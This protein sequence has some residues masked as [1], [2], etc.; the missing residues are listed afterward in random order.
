[1]TLFPLLSLILDYFQYCQGMQE[2]CTM[3]L[4]LCHFTGFSEV[5]YNMSGSFGFFFSHL[6]VLPVEVVTTIVFVTN[7]VG[8]LVVDMPICNPFGVLI[9]SSS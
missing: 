8:T 5:N 9:L 1:M 7:L 6:Q 2:T 3:V 4:P